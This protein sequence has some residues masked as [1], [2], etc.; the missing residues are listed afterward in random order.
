MPNELSKGLIPPE[1]EIRKIV[2]QMMQ[3]NPMQ[4]PVV[5]MQ[6]MVGQ[7][8]LKYLDK[9]KSELYSSIEVLEKELDK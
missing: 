2:A 5:L 4:I 7:L 1:D 6:I 8:M 9:L 3:T